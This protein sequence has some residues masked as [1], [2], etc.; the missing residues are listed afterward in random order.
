MRAWILKDGNK[1]IKECF[2]DNIVAIAKNEEK[3]NINLEIC[4][5]V[6]EIVTIK[7]HTREKN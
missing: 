7:I 1:I 4:R 6:L 5:Y 3:M 2:T